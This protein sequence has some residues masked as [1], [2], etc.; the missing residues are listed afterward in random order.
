MNRLLTFLFCTF[1]VCCVLT[2]LYGVGT[3]GRILWN[4]SAVVL[5]TIGAVAFTATLRNPLKG[6]KK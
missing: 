6:H 3:T 4:T 5:L 1:T 2:A